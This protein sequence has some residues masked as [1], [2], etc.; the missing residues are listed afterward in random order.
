[1]SILVHYCFCHSESASFFFCI[2]HLKKKNCGSV[3]E[4]GNCENLNFH[5]FCCPVLN[6]EIQEYRSYFA[7]SMIHF[8]MEQT[9]TTYKQGNKKQRFLNLK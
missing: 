3:V 7:H 6:V 8:T 2:L 4:F 5:M 1:M 9:I